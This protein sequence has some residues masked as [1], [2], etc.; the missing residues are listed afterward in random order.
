V[1]RATAREKPRNFQNLSIGISRP[2]SRLIDLK[3]GESARIVDLDGEQALVQRLL[4]MGLTD[5]EVVEVVRYA[6]MGDPLE[7]RIRGYNLSIR[8]SEA[9]AILID[10]A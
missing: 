9:A 5:G 1:A 4:E 8:R 10:K 7:V 6:P 2:V 3:P